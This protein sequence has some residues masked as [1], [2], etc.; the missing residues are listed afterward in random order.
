MS[1]HDLLLVCV[2]VA[3]ALETGLLKGVRFLPQPHVTELRLQLQ[4]VNDVSD[5]LPGKYVIF[6][7]SHF[8]S[9]QIWEDGECM[10][11]PT[12]RRHIGVSKTWD[13]G[14]LAG[15][16]KAVF[17][18]TSNKETT[19]AENVDV[20]GGMEAVEADGISA[21]VSLGN[22]GEVAELDSRG[23]AAGEVCPS[24]PRV[25]ERVMVL[26]ME[27][28]KSI[29]SGEKTLE[30]RGQR[31]K[32][33]TVW[34]GNGAT[35]YG[36]VDI[37]KVDQLDMDS[38]V[39]L[40]P[41]HCYQGTSLPYAATYGLWLRS[42]RS[43]SKP[44]P[45]YKLFGS[46]GW[47]VV[48]FSA[49]DLPAPRKMSAEAQ[50]ADARAS[51]QAGLDTALT[52]APELAGEGGMCNV[53]NSCYQNSLFQALL[54]SS[55][56]TTL[57]TNHLAQQRP[58]DSEC[59]LCLL[60]MTNVARSAGGAGRQVMESW[61]PALGKFGYVKGQADSP[62]PLADTLCDAISAFDVPGL[63]QTSFAVCCCEML[64]LL[65][66]AKLIVSLINV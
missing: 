27:W 45:F 54:H 46:I 64:C 50:E 49:R 17:K 4:H 22:D 43:L 61:A 25:G 63:A 15:G 65:E 59:L 33:G 14:I 18:L 23:D 55:S 26:K 24:V 8:T 41:A 28:L 35:I 20:L 38:F 37:E 40:R 9:L 39:Q 21:R 52:Q 31:A 66:L 44:I 53:G 29:L 58:C 2:C 42:P 5:M 1:Q 36:S 60:K 7:F 19:A 34:L 48:R 6:C 56:L 32:V 57:V 13:A 30:L 62:L 47:A 3:L 10:I 12:C 51:K 16:D 11:R